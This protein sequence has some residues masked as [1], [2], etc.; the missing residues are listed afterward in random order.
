MATQCIEQ[1]IEDPFGRA[2]KV[3]VN[4]HDRPLPGCMR[5]GI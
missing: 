2:Q 1:T 5:G 3:A 4:L